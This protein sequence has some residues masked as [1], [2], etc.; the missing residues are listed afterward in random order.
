MTHAPGTQGASVT[1]TAPAP[2]TD[3]V[4]DPPLDPRPVPAGLDRVGD[5]RRAGAGSARAGARRTA[6][7]RWRF[8][9]SRFRSPLGLLV[10][11]YP[12]LAKVRY[13]RLDTVT[14]DRRMLGASLVLNW[15]VGPAL[16][17]ALAWVFLSDLPEYRT[18]LIIV[19]LA[20]CIAMVIIWNDLAAVTAR[21]QRCSSRSTRSSRSSP[22]GRSAGS[23][24]RCCPGGSA[25]SR[26]PRR[27]ALADRRLGARLPRH[28]AATRLPLA[29]GGRTTLGANGIRGVVPPTHRSLGALR[30][31]LHD[32][33]ALR[34]AG[35][36]DHEQPPRRRTDRPAAAGVLRDHVGRRVR[37]RPRARYV[38][39]AHDDARLH[40]RGQQ[41]RAGDRRLD[42][43][44]RGDVGAGPGRRRR[45]LIEVPVLV[46]LVYVSLALRQRFLHG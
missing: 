18:G 43:D 20:R 6:C 30:A 26:S 8:A 4:A 37:A 46:G 13:D 10:M 23:T 33:R 42:R 25:S 40:R 34:T 12:V 17:F 39:R 31:T 16:M 41:L 24:S 28:P 15:V 19:G 22:S 32:R 1:A 27:L 7:R 21:P 35:R 3:H 2:P 5:G 36:A 9:G 11:M 44:V 38:V 45:P 29:H 14:G